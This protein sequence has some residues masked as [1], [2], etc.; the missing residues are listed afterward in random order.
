MERLIMSNK[1]DMIPFILGATTSTFFMDLFEKA[2]MTSVAMLISTT[3]S[4][5]WR[6]YLY[7][8]FKNFL[9]K[10]ENNKNK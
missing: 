5:F 3:L 10:H 4:F 1:Y 9:R 8:K 6:R 2:I 7:A